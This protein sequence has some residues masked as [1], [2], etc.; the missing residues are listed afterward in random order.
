MARLGC[1]PWARRSRPRCRASGLGVVGGVCCDGCVA[2]VP[3]GRPLHRLRQ[4]E[5]YRWHP[6]R[7]HSAPARPRER[8]RSCWACSGEGPGPSDQGPPSVIWFAPR[9]TF[10]SRVI[11]TFTQSSWSASGT[12]TALDRFRQIH[13][14]LVVQ[15]GR[16]H[17]ED[18]Q[19]N[20]HHVHHRRDVD[21]RINFFAFVSFCNSHRETPGSATLA[22]N[23]AIRLAKIL[24]R[25]SPVGWRCFQ[26]PPAATVIPACNRL[27]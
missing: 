13:V 10:P 7:C 5:G 24:S 3:S 1:I 4:C 21:V 2:P 15:H 12:A 14:D 18:D 8:T 27:S 20:Q 26:S 9:Y 16:D 17:H 25:I 22:S 6:S 19:Q 11:D 23:E